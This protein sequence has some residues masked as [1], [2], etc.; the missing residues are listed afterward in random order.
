M[1][2]HM[3]KR[4][5]NLIHKKSLL[6]WVSWG[7]CLCEPII[8]ISLV[9]FCFVLLKP[10]VWFSPEL[11]DGSLILSKTS[12]SGFL[13]SC[14][15]KNLCFCFFLCS[16]WKEPLVPGLWNFSKDL[17]VLV[18]EPMAS[19]RFFDRICDNLEPL[20]KDEFFEFW[21]LL[22]KG[23]HISYIYPLVPGSKNW[24]PP[25]TSFSLHDHQPTNLS[26]LRTFLH[27]KWQNHVIEPVEHKGY[28]K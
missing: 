25:N 11:L 24:Q 26:L 15:S 16:E 4:N 2:L 19:G 23:K 20:D 17:P 12:G 27:T 21:D 18:K 1:L 10:G 8:Q 14:W 22:L 28:R 9:L 3:V 7:R 5:P 6:L 13:K